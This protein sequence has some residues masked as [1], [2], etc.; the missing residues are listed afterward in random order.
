MSPERSE[1]PSRR[2][3]VLQRA[4]RV[5][6]RAWRGLARFRLLRDVLGA[7]LIVVGLAVVAAAST[8][9]LRTLGRLMPV[10]MAAA[11]VLTANHYVLDVLAGAA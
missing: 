8:L 4:R 9:A 5:G 1:R 6:G 11:T 7:L 3:R 2:S 10:L